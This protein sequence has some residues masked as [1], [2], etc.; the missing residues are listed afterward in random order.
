MSRS[1]RRFRRL[2]M[3]AVMSLAPVPVALGV[4]HG[5]LDEGRPLRMSDPY[6]VAYREWAVESGLRFHRFRDG[7][8]RWALSTEV[9]YGAAPDLHVGALIQA[10]DSSE[11]IEETTRPGDVVVGALYSFNQESLAVSR[12]SVSR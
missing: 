9:L 4:D 7:T 8:D 6:P 12:R 1:T 5:N 10:S 2:L 11:P 3:I